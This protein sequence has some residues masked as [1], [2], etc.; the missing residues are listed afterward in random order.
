MQEVGGKNFEECI[1]QVP[2][3][4]N[5]I[6]GSMHEM[7]YST[8][9]A[10][11]DLE[12]DLPESY[13]ALGS[14]FFINDVTLPRIRQ[15]DF[16]GKQFVK[17][18]KV[19]ESYDRGLLKCRMLRKAKFPKDFWPTALGSL[20]FINDVTL[21]RIRQ[22]D[23]VGKQFVKLEKVFES[24]DRGLL[25]C[26][27]LRKAKFPKDFWP[28]VKWGRKGYMHCRF[29][30]DQTIYDFVNVHLFH[31]ESNIALIHEVSISFY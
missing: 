25:K 13:I 22:Y 7:G 23:F 12:F 14:L 15:Y 2:T 8:G 26:R 11:L 19:F 28:T 10:Y 27:M 29:R 30:F 5:H 17:L 3:F 21:P 20:F 24:Y 18:E 31:D 1:G 16:V 4:L 9:R 6:S